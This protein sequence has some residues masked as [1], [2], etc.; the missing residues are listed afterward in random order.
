ML[1]AARQAA[2]TRVK[3]GVMKRVATGVAGGLV[4]LV[5]IFGV[6][7]AIECVEFFGNG[8]LVLSA[9]SFAVMIA[10]GAALVFRAVTNAGR[11]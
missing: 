2:D 8:I 7:S 5:G 9:I 4:F 10:T 3:S 11:Y 1:E 6:W